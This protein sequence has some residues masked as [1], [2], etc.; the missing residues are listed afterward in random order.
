M[1]NLFFMTL[2]SIAFS[3]TAFAGASEDLHPIFLHPSDN[4][5]SFSIAG[6]NACPPK[7]QCCPPKPQCCPRPCPPKPIG[8]RGPRGKHGK[9]GERGFKGEREDLKEKGVGMALQAI[10]AAQAQQA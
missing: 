9:K 8:E 5:S 1:I 4:N 7:P 2:L 6:C 10:E 3:L